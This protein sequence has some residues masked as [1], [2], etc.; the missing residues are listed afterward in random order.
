MNL[1]NVKEII[2]P[3]GRAIH[4]VSSKTGTLWYKSILPDIYQ[5]IAWIEAKPDVGAYIDL[6]F[7]FDTAAKVYMSCYVDDIS[8]TA[9]PFG[10]AENS[11]ALRCCVSCPF[12][13]CCYQYGS[14]GSVYDHAVLDMVTGFSD[15]EFVWQ[16]GLLRNTNTS[17]NNTIETTTQG[18]YAMTSNLYLFA[19]NYNGSP[20]FG[21][22]RR[23]SKFKYYDKNNVLICNLIPCYRKSDD[24]IGMYD[25]VRQMF[26]TNVGSGTFS[27]EFVPN[28]ENLVYTSTDTDGS[29]YN[30]TGY[31]NNV[32]LSSSGGISSS[33]Q[34][35]SVTT[36]FISING[37]LDVIRI[38]GVEWKGAT[39][40]YDGH[41]YF[42]YYDANK[43]FLTYLSDQEHESYAHVVT[44]TRDVNGVETLVWNND[45]GTSNSMLE[46]VRK[47]SYVRITAHGSGLDMIVTRNEELI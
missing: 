31:K 10:A 11:G 17:T 14:T 8:T 26:L 22:R 24:V 40:K 30:G 45:Y 9:Y 23:I 19:Q 32:R 29:I 25:T 5:E 3:E 36:G 1:A 28:Y 15:Y 6:G 27:R 37:A 13:A 21:G 33:A 2:I 44:M 34:N 42:N 18:E 35:G 4:L 47:S 16:N 7:S 46:H 41:F 39:A 43:K 20:R 38:A 12:D